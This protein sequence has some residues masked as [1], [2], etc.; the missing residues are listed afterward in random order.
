MSEKISIIILV[1][2]F[3]IFVFPRFFL[4]TPSGDINNFYNKEISNYSSISKL[5]ESLYKSSILPYSKVLWHYNLVLSLFCSFLFLYIFNILTSR[6][7]II[8]V[9]LFFVIIEIPN[10]FIS[11]HYNSINA[12]YSTSLYSILKDRLNYIK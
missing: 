7:L 6:N 8:C 5:L 10:R 4:Y 1:V 3:I 9:F 11:A 12:N 2:I